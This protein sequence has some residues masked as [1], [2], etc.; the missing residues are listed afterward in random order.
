MILL[1]DFAQY[2]QN[3]T[4]WLILHVYGSYYLPLAVKFYYTIFTIEYMD[5]LRDSLQFE[6]LNVMKLISYVVQKY[7]PYHLCFR[8][9]LDEF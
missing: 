3:C 1:F 2:A 5:C 4:I 8:R 9:V 6:R 7:F